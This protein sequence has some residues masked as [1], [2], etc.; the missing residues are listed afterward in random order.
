MPREYIPATVL[1]VM[2]ALA[3][4]MENEYMAN[5]IYGNRIPEWFWGMMESLGLLSE[6]DSNY[7]VDV[8]NEII[9]NFL[10]KRYGRDGF[11]SLFCFPG[12]Y[13]D[14]SMDIWSQMLRFVSYRIRQSR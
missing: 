1:E 8:A 9:D 7:S 12:C 14:S 5:D 2:I 11:G 10:E 13:V 3:I 4:R 6:D